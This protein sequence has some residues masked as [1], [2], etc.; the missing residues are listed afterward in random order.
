M[1]R[2]NMYITTKASARHSLEKEWSGKHPP[3]RKSC[4]KFGFLCQGINK[5]TTIASFYNIILLNFILIVKW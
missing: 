4:S 3:R 5:C 2:D 1:A